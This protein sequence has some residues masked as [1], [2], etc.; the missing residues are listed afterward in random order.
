M[1]QVMDLRVSHGEAMEG[2]LDILAG[3]AQEDRKNQMA[4]TI[5]TTESLLYPNY[6]KD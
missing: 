1:A 5:E 6:L 3:H 2:G 4:A